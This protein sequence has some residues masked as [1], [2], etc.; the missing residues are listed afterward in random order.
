M[1]TQLALLRAVNVGGHG[2]VPMARVREVFLNLG[3]GE[4]RTLLQSGNVV[5]EASG[6]RAL[7]EKRIESA[8]AEQLGLQT[9]VMVRSA[10]G[11]A[12][13]MA[14]NPFPDEAKRDPAHL[15]L[16]VLK[17]TPRA[18]A[19]EDLRAAIRGPELFHVERDHAYIVYPNGIG[20]SKLTSQVIE[21][22]IGTRATARNWSTVL[23]LAALA[24]V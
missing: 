19:V 14:G 7:L 15:V 1:T 4:A 12:A 13:I 16:A 23:K 9:E 18:R 11:W 3:F 22:R 8:L 2:K 5:F 10:A 17:G 20:R 21:S 24:G 6:P